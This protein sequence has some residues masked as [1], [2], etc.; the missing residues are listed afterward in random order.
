[1]LRSDRFFLRSTAH[2]VTGIR[3]PAQTAP[4]GMNTNRYKGAADQYA[5]VSPAKT[6]SPTDTPPLPVVTS[7]EPV[8]PSGNTHDPPQLDGGRAGP[9]PSTHRATLRIV[10]VSPAIS[11]CALPAIHT[12]SQMPSTA[13]RISAA[14]TVPIDLNLVDAD[15]SSGCAMSSDTIPPVCRCEVHCE[16][17]QCPTED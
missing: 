15:S 14:T 1:M 16:G 8:R 5:H 12:T 10:A 9:P 3:T 11:F 2:I 13:G 7:P 17:S 6:V 4:M